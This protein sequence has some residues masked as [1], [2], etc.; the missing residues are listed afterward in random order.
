MNVSPGPQK[1]DRDASQG[2]ISLDYNDESSSPISEEDQSATTRT[3]IKS[4]ASGLSRK[5]QQPAPAGVTYPDAVLRANSYPF[6]DP[7]AGPS[8][9]TNVQMALGRVTVGDPNMF[10]PKPACS[11][12][13]IPRLNVQA[14][15]ARAERVH[16]KVNRLLKESSQLIR[17]VKKV[18]DDFQD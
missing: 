3:T 18:M 17:A 7:D 4:G 11:D 6:S 10:D 8:G 12:A 13:K 9:I 5:R 16:N 1:P 2:T 14:M 15:R